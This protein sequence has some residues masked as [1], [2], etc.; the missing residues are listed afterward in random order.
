MNKFLPYVLIILL[1]GAGFWY[2]KKEEV[3]SPVSPVITEEE[4]SITVQAVSLRDE[5]VCQND[6]DCVFQVQE[7]KKLDKVLESESKDMCKKLNL[8]TLQEYCEL[9][10]SLK[11]AMKNIAKGGSVLNECKTI[12][13][14]AGPSLFNM[15]TEYGAVVFEAGQKKDYR[16]C[17]N[18]SNENAANDCELLILGL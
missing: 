6:E 4:T 17:Q 8:Q 12:K 1:I 16:I 3:L 7:F 18:L 15:C 5:T 2:W 11:H 13:E 10:V 9:E 14:L